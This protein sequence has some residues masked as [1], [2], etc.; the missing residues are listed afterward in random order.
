MTARTSSRSKESILRQI[1]KKGSMESYLESLSPK[2]VK[3]YK[4]ILLDIASKEENNE[5]L[6]SLINNKINCADPDDVLYMEQ[7]LEYF[8]KGAA[9][10]DYAKIVG[11]EYSLLIIILFAPLSIGHL[12]DLKVGDISYET[13][14]YRIDITI[15]GTQNISFALFSNLKLAS[16]ILSQLLSKTKDSLVL[17]D[18]ERS[19]ENIF[20]IISKRIRSKHKFTGGIDG[21]Q[22]LLIA[23]GHIEQ[24]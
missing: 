14:E 13:F 6:T 23:N 4:R 24:I 18:C 10:G 22:K 8:Q 15:K 21:F 9:T 5:Y 20:N 16:F 2:T 1:K 7:V 17:E 12:K 19:L 11:K 3:N